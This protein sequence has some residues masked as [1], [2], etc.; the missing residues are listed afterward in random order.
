MPIHLVVD[1]LYNRLSV[2]PVT[3]DRFTYVDLARLKTKVYMFLCQ[4]AGGTEK[5]VG[6]DLRT[7]YATLKITDA[8]W[9][10]TRNALIATLEHCLVP[11]R[12]TR[13]VLALI[14]SLKGD[15][16]HA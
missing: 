14:D 3:R 10:T 7:A 9:Q 4:A 1:G 11:V 12:E 15:I 8:E 16:V 6:L 2:D 13:D 5:Y